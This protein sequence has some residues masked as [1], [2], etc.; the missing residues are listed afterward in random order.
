MEAEPLTHLTD[1]SL[2]ERF[3]ATGEPAIFAEIFRR[4]RSGIFLCC[5]AIVRDREVAADQTQGTFLKALE[6]IHT[7]APGNLRAWLITIAKHQSIN[8]LRARNKGPQQLDEVDF[9]EVAPSIE[10]DLVVANSVRELMAVL[11][12]PQR[13]CLKLFWLNGLTYDEIAVLTGLDAGAVKSHI[14]NGMKRMRRAKA[15]LENQ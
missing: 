7:F 9:P 4:Y 6:G 11:S 13:R 12:E 1:S 8:H 15:Q 10:Q 5:L 14:Q 2:V 3:Q